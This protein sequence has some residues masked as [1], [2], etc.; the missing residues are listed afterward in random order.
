MTTKRTGNGKN[1][2]KSRSLG[3]TNKR[4]GN[5]KNDGKGR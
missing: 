3:M 5:D 4:T 2:D 1:D